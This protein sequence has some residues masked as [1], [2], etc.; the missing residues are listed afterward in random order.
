MSRFAAA[1]MS[2]GAGWS[3]RRRREQPGMAVLRRLR[4]RRASRSTIGCSLKGLDDPGALSGIGHRP[5]ICRPALAVTDVTL[6]DDLR[7]LLEPATLGD[8]MRPLLWLSKGHAKLPDALRAMGHQ[9]GKSGIPEVLGFLHY[10]RQVNRKT[11]EGSRD[12]DRDAQFEHINAAVIANQAAGQPVT[13][14]DTKKKE[15]IGPYKN[16]GSD[17]RPEGDPALARVHDFVDPE[18]GKVVPYGIY[19]I[20]ATPDWD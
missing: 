15:L 16:V 14:I 9:I 12:P 2:A 3:R 17:Y 19:E 1:L 4:A 7:R 8:P 18:L 13:S 5:G 11:V 10:C 20:A 6:L